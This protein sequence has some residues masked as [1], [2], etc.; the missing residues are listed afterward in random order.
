[1]TKISKRDLISEIQNKTD[2]TFNVARLQYELYR[3]LKVYT[4]TLKL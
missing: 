4:L 1:M 3:R 2:C